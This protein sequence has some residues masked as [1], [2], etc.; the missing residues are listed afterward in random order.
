MGHSIKLNK[1]LA[2]HLA[3]LGTIFDPSHEYFDVY[4]SLTF[5]LHNNVMFNCGYCAAQ[6]MP[7]GQGLNAGFVRAMER[8]G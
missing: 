8:Q 2:F 3:F 5:T 6:S 7:A 1:L 4:G